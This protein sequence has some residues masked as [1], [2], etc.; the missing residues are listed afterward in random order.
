V[1]PFDGIVTARQVSV[2]ELV[3][4]SGTQV[5]ATIVQLDPIYVNFNASE[6]DVLHVRDMLAQRK[7]T[8]AN[9]LGSEV[10]VGLQT[11]QGFPHKGKL[12]YVAPL[13]NAGTGTLAARAELQNPQ[14]LLLPGF[15]VRVRVP[16]EETPAVLIPTVSLGSDQAGRYVL[17]VD[18][19]NVVQQRKVTTGPVV[20][21][22]TV[23]E[24]G[25]KTD[26]RVIVEGL[27][28]AIPGQKVDPQTQTAAK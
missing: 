16:L 5:L 18:G 27:L 23:V 21:Q 22:M 9:L 6:R 17:T 14:R 2:G 11:D 19:D 24:T 4:G 1:A 8:A 12:N 10:D 26:D 28:R 25:L 13:V 7:Q 15:F 3:G 20:G